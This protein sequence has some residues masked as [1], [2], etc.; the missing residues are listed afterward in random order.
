MINKIGRL[1]LDVPYADKDKVK[2]LGA[3]WD[4]SIKKWYY[5]G[6]AYNY[7]K[8][9]D[10]LPFDLSDNIIVIDNIYI[11]EGK[12]ICWKCKKETTVIALGVCENIEVFFDYEKDKYVCNIDNIFCELHLAWAYEEK[13]IPPLLL[14]YIK[15]QYSVKTGYSKR[16]GKNFANHCQ[17]C[18]TIQGNNFLFEESDSPFSNCAFGDVLRKRM[19]KLKIKQIPIAD[20]I[21]LDWNISYS[22]NDFAYLDYC[23][24]VEIINIRAEGTN[25]EPL[26]YKDLY[27]L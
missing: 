7:F 12:R 5:R 14:K 25:T 20:N 11:L 15:S 18:G 1:Y 23:D 22:S 4:S 2:A 13:Q 10:W 17:H 24:D 26:T 21:Q 3:K 6:S 27:L 16:A 8:F 19:E 9:A